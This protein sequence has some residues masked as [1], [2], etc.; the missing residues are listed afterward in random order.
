MNG[1]RPCG[2]EFRSTHRE[3]GFSLL[4]VLIALAISVALLVAVLTLFDRNSQLARLEAE[5]TETQQSVRAVHLEVARALRSA[6]RGGLVQNTPVK[7]L[8]HLGVAI[9][10]AS[11]VAGA[12]R[13][14]APA[15]AGSPEAVAGT[16]I[17]RARGVFSS[18]VYQSHDNDDARTFLVLRDA[19]GTFI[20]DPTL[21]REGELHLCASSPAGFPQPL[22]PL[23]EAIRTGSEEAIVLAS[24]ADL[25]EYAVVKL[26]P[27]RSAPTSAVCNP[28]DPNGGVKLSFTVSGDGGR[29]DRYHELSPSGGA[30]LPS[31]LTSVAYAAILEEYAYYVREIREDPGQAGSPL[32]PRFSRA[33]LYPNTG[34]AWGTDAA[35]QE[36]SV[37]MDVADDIFDFQVSLGLD[38]AQGGGAIADGSAAAQPLYESADGQGDDWLFNSDQDD[39]AAPVWDRPGSAGLT[40]PWLRAGLYYVRISTLGRGGRPGASKYRAAALGSLED[41]AYD[42][43][44]DDDP[45]SPIQRQYHR[46]VLSTTFDLRNL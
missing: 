15:L 45:D 23:R 41:R 30:G 42:G 36:S 12:D 38:S 35:T 34:S 2:H 11:N 33:R 29:A 8:P 28:A 37:A 24:S 6:G 18:P 20:Q 7:R 17:L 25:G 32:M 19:S 13:V 14:V 22:D 31:S 4:E 1:S 16:D 44:S 3:D 5:M 21:A 43:L 10:V 40:E 27:G 26:V 9:E 39:P 46:W